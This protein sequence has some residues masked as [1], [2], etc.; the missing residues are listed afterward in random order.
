MHLSP[1]QQQVHVDLVIDGLWTDESPP[2]HRTGLTWTMEP[3]FSLG[4]QDSASVNDGCPNFTP[5]HV[6]KT[7]CPLS[8]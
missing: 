8:N 3:A 7:V 5:T 6:L 1:L 2:L 4:V